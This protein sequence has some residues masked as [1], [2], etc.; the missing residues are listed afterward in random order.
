[1]EDNHAATISLLLTGNIPCPPALIQEKAR[2][3]DA[4]FSYSDCFRSLKPMIEKADLTIGALDASWEYPDEFIE[5]LKST[6]FGMLTM[7]YSTKENDNREALCRA[8]DAKQLR[9]PKGKTVASSIIKIGDVRIGIIDCTFH[10]Q[11]Q[12]MKVVARVRKKVEIMKKEHVDFTLCY[13]HWHFF[14]DNTLAIDERQRIIAK[15]LAQ[16]GVNYIVGS[17]SLY[18][19]RYETLTSNWNRKTPVA[20]S[21]GN[22]LGSSSLINQNVSAIIKLDIQ[23]TR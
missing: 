17:G 21:L 6:G 8:L 3:T 2:S 11:Y 4:G 16:A 7:G 9:H 1:M 18:L 15:A 10:H 23:K 22:L 20:Y 12:D 13:V 14:I 19:M 5:A